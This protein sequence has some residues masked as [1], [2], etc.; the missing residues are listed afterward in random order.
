MQIFDHTIAALSTPPGKG[1]VAL[2]RIS[3]RDARDVAERVFHAKSGKSVFALAPRCAVYGD[4][5]FEGEAIDDVLLTVFPAPNSYTGEDTVEITCHGASPIV[6]A[7]LSALFAAGAMPAAPGEFTRRAFVAGKLSLSEAEAIG[8]LLDAKSLSGVKLFGRDSRH[9]LSVALSSLY[10]DVCHLLSSLLAVID[11]P[12]EDLAELSEDEILMRLGEIEARGRRLLATYRTGSAVKDGIPTVLLGKPN[13]GK[14]TLYN[15]LCGREAA[16]VTE[17]AGTTRDVLEATVPLGRVLL[18]LSD[19]AGVRESEDAVER[20]GVLRSKE[21]AERASLV[22]VLFD[23]ARA[24]DAEDEAL[25]SFLDTLSGVKVAL[26][27][28]SDLA[29]AF[30][31]S[32]LEGH[33]SHVLPFSAKTGDTTALSALVDRLFTDDSLTI[34]EDAILFSPRAYA[35]LLRG[36]EALSR[37]AE[38]LRA[39]GAVDAA[40]MEAESALAAFAECD[41]KEVSEDVVSDI[42]K[43][44]CVGK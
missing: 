5:L 11:Y 23:G 20:I 10:E 35:A 42:F 34:G 12:D 8:E 21:A 19:T 22:F 27:N 1:G 18:R 31:A 39:T 36:C 41:G 16:I 4:V 7:I 3:G 32:V 43:H 26:L 40:L 15:L 6:E 9:R 14:S 37:A 28:K 24:C 30:D 2:I 44:F 29:S 17:I 25:L 33:V 38:A 13:T